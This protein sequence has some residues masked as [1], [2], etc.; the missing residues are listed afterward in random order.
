[1]SDSTE[2]Y[3]L[4]TFP[5]GVNNAEDVFNTA[6][7][8]LDVFAQPKFES[9]TTTAEPTGTSGQLWLVPASATGANWEDRDGEI[10]FFVGPPFIRGEGFWYFLT[11][12]EGFVAY[13]LDDEEWVTYNGTEWWPLLDTVPAAIS[14]VATPD[15]TSAYSQTNMQNL[16]DGIDALIAAYGE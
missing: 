10:A 1:M 6:L 9:R 8:I 11:P 7:F 5:E 16:I 13:V 3:E 15:S 2:R 12:P 4:P 14:D